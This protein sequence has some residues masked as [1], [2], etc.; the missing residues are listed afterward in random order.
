MRIRIPIL[1]FLVWTVFVWV[2][3]IRNIVSDDDLSGGAMAWRLGAA[4]LF[5]MLALAVFVVGRQGER[6]SVALLG[7][8]VV[9]TIGWWSIRGVGIL[10]DGNHEIGFKVVHTV[11]MIVSIG[12]AMWAWARRDG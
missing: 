11:L 5:V 8:L 10:L 4:V 1:G 9:W 7:V 2:G 6:I 3:R 12:L